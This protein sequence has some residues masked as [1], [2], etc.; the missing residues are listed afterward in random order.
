MIFCI[1]SF[2]LEMLIS[3]Y[4]PIYTKLFFPLFTLISLIPLHTNIK[5][6][7]KY[8]IT[9]FILGFF[10]DVTYTNTIILNAIVFTLISYIIINLNFKIFNKIISLCITTLLVIIIYQII[11]YLILLLTTYLVFEIHD[12]ITS[13][14]S[15]LLLNIIYSIILFYLNKY[16]K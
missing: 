5:N 4:I 1:I 8:L 9:S 10:Y 16:S 3:N 7:K 6:K 11:T 2:I 15:S 13:I 14:T 12:L